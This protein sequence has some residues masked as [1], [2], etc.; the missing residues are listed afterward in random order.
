MFCEHD[1]KL[2]SE[3][4]TESKL[5]RLKKI[6]GITPGETIPYYFLDQKVIQNLTCTKCG[7]LKHFVEV[8]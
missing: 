3:T 6:I 4:I 1:W 7:K 5:E 8:V 2:I